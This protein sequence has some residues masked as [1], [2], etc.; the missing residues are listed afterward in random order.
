MRLQDR[1]GLAERV[2]TPAMAWSIHVF[3]ATGVVFGLLGLLSVLDGSPR[4]ALLWLMVAQIVDGL[5]GPMARV[6]SVKL[7]LPRMDGNVLDLVID[8][9]TCV[10]AP[11]VFIHQFNLMPRWFS[12]PGAGLV[13]LTSLYCF[14]RLDLMTDDHYFRGFPAMWNLAVNVMFVLQSRP[15]VNFF[16]VITLSLLVFAPVYVPHPIRVRQHRQVTIAVI[17]V[18]LGTMVYLTW[19]VGQGGTPRLHFWA[20]AIEIGGVLY[21]AWLTIERTYLHRSASVGSPAT[22]A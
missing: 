18:W 8:Y 3:T 17:V 4:A 16:V 15:I 5:D 2:Q 6:C 10:V 7:V 19:V 20:D 9:V 1:P 14:G 11:A 13:M 12:L 21:L 22:T